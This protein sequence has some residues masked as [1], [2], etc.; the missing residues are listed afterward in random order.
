MLTNQSGGITPRFVRHPSGSVAGELVPIPSAKLEY[1]SMKYLYPLC[2]LFVVL[3]ASGCMDEED[4]PIIIFDGGLEI[5]A[6]P[7]L[8]EVRSGDFDLNDLTGSTYEHFV[9]FVDGNGG[10]DVETYRILVAFRSVSGDQGETIVFR[11]IPATEFENFDGT[12]NKAFTLTIPF[13][14]VAGSLNIN[15]EDVVS[16][17]RFRFRTE[18]VNRDGQVFNSANSRPAVTNAFGGIWNWDVTASCPLDDNSFVGTYS[19]EYGYVYDEFELFEQ[20]V[21]P[22]GVPLAR[23]VE[24]AFSPGQRTRRTFNYGSYLVPGF[25]FS[26][27]DI[28]LD[29][30]CTV[31]THS[32]INSGEGCGPSPI[33]AVQNGQGEF[34]LTD[35]TSFT[36]ELIDFAPGF[37]GGCG[38]APREYSVVFTKQ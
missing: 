33:Q 14:E 30:A 28:S 13:T 20:P 7:R 4:G 22:F 9:D 29:F 27:D 10:E 12:G 23:T 37:D 16:G 2:F 38:P 3:F 21:T 35:D 25:N 6:F 24:L 31:L 32:N 5:G 8:Q 15:P 34:D 36:V 1:C 19:I 26:T 18:L 11:E 17:D